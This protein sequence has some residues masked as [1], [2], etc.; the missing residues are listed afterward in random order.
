MILIFSSQH[1][2]AL[3]SVITFVFSHTRPLAHVQPSSM[4]KPMTPHC[5]CCSPSHCKCDSAF[6]ARLPAV[7]PQPSLGAHRPFSAACSTSPVCHSMCASCV[8]STACQ[9]WAPAL[10][11]GGQLC[12]VSICPVSQALSTEVETCSFPQTPWLLTQATAQLFL[13]VYFS[14]SGALPEPFPL[15]HLL[16]SPR[17]LS[18]PGP[19][20]A[21]ALGFLHT[22]GP[23]SAD[24]AAE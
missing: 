21:A 7:L 14:R 22:R 24:R 23:C 18:M 9:H 4:P 5:I 6:P 17:P 13:L 10:S 8:T 15:G 2:L 19:G 1:G 3:E 11:P 20:L 16:L 12:L